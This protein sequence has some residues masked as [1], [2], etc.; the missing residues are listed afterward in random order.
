M[1]SRYNREKFPEVEQLLTKVLDGPPQV[2]TYEVSTQHLQAHCS[3]DGLKTTTSCFNIPFGWC[4]FNGGGLAR[5][6]HLPTQDNFAANEEVPPP[7]LPALSP[8]HNRK[9]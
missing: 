8:R 3:H 5:P 2:K 1:L 9:G 4:C 7:M 6:L